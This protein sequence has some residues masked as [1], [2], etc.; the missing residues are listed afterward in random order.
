MLSF[1]LFGFTS[2]FEIYLSRFI[3]HFTI[4]VLNYLFLTN[5]HDTYA[6]D[7]RVF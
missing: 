3:F 1:I 7:E 6:K 2:R 5:E 4:S